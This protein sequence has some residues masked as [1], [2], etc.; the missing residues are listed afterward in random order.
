MRMRAHV[1]APP[2]HELHRTHLIEEDER[3]DHLPFAV[4]QRAANGKA[5]T[6]IA[7]PGN[8]DQFKRIARVFVAEHRILIRQPAHRPAPIS[9]PKLPAATPIAAAAAPTPSFAVSGYL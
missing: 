1:H 5:V 4:R 8:D 6:E 2:G 7:H 3:P 9:G